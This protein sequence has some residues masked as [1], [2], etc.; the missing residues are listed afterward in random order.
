MKDEIK[1]RLEYHPNP[2]CC[3]IHLN[4]ELISNKTHILGSEFD[5]SEELGGEKKAKELMELLVNT[6]GIDYIF[7]KKFSISIHKGEVFDWEEVI[8][9]VLDVI[10]T[11]LGSESEMREKD[12]PIVHSP[13]TQKEI[14]KLNEAFDDFDL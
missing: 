4:K 12:A 10:N 9:N 6:D 3:E 11:L 7:I 8:P 13:L 5:S 1:Y 14:E 2:N